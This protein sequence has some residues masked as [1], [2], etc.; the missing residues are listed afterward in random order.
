MNQWTGVNRTNY[1]A[2]T[3]RPRDVM[4]QIARRSD[5]QGRTN[6]ASAGCARAAKPP[7]QGPV[8]VS[9]QPIPTAFRFNRLVYVSKFCDPPWFFRGVAIHILDKYTPMAYTKH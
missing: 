6:A 7:V 9:G 4:Y 5:V 8:F 2:Y 3:H 1:R